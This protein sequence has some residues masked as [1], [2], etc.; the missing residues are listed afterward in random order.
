MGHVVR[1][2][3]NMLPP[4]VTI[5]T[6]G[7]SSEDLSAVPIDDARKALLVRF[8]LQLACRSGESEKAD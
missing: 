8:P 1:S 3:A 7:R 5:F 6:W 4:T 2:L